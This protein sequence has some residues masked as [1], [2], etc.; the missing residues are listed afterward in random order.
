MHQNTSDRVPDTC[1]TSNPDAYQEDILSKVSRTFALTIPQLPAPLRRVVGNAYLLCR[2]ADTIEDEVGLTPEQK[3]DFHDEFISVVAGGGDADRFAATVYPLLSQHTLVAERDLIRN[4]PVVVSVTHQLSMAQ[5]TT[6]ERCLNIMCQGMP[7]FQ[8]HTG[9]GGLQD[10]RQLDR[11]CY[12]V[13]G[14]VGEMLT[15]LFCAYSPKI[16]KHR[17]A[18][19]PL[20]ISFGQGLQM[21]NILRDVW[22]D[23]ENEVC[24]LPQDVFGQERCDLRTLA[25]GQYN[26]GFS[27]G[28]EKMIAIAHAHLRNALAYTLL[29][30]SDETG[31]R[32]FCLWAVGFAVLSLRKLQNT[33]AYA[34]G[35]PVKISRRSVR[36]VMAM[37]NAAVRSDITL[38]TLF[39][40][41]AHGLPSSALDPGWAPWEIV[42]SSGRD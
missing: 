4:T 17:A 6:I 32:R 20:A 3:R 40:W 8:Y 27:S 38:R 28:I 23:R 22:K 12:C 24:W 19:M 18:L 31:I 41:A 5:R 21:T 7:A 35:G 42:D 14:V 2:I 37:G 1:L 10:M 39:R 26:K 11:Y 9:L 15:E 33:A 25:S 36:V 16:G 13:A 29:I 34:A 30:P